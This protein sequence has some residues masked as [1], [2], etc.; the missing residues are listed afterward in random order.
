[1]PIHRAEHKKNF[2]MILNAVLNDT[3]LSYGARGLM[4]HALTHYD[5]WE[6]T[7]EEY[8]TNGKDKIAKIKGYI[9]E[10][11]QYGYLK[12]TREKN[13][14]GRLGNAIYIFREVPKC[15][16]PTLE[17]YILDENKEKSEVEPKVENPT[18]EKPTLDLPTLENH[19]PNNTNINNNI[20]SHWNSKKIIRHKE[21]SEEMKKA[22]NKALKK[23]SEDEIIQAIDT[24]DEILKSDFFFN[25]KWSLTD[26]LNRKNGI[27]TFT[28][29]GSNKANYDTWNS[30]QN[31]NV[32]E[33][34]YRIF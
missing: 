25:Y 33:N 34:S 8:F 13:D 12:R 4:A 3:R 22:I 7:G 21:L 9:K 14:K 6:F 18:L 31:I 32:S 19:T 26:F 28:E 2:T 30:K 11:I 17:K 24:Y 5:D 1:M 10:L 27:S 20:Y 16:N 23:Y 29:E 15:E